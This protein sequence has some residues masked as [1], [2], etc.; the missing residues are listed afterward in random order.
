MLRSCVKQTRMGASLSGGG[1][2]PSHGPRRAWPSQRWPCPRVLGQNPAQ[3]GRRRAPQSV[4]LGVKRSDKRG[5]GVWVW[6]CQ[7]GSASGRALT[8]GR[9]RRKR[10]GVSAGSGKKQ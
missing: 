10:A 1:A 3:Q 2:R 7:R 9:Q 5:V 4:A 6:A 8:E